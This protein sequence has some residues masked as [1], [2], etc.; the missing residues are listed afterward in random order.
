MSTIKNT[1]LLFILIFGVS[2]G[3][4]QTL[5]KT[6]V[7]GDFTQFSRRFYTDSLFQMSRINFPLKGSHNINVP[8]RGKNI[9]GD[10]IIVGWKKKDW[11]MVTN[12]YFK[13]NETKVKIDNTTY[14]RKTQ[15]G[16][17]TAVIRTYIENSGFEVVEKYAILNGKWYLVY[18]S[19][20]DY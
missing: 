13:N 18:F 4:Q 5:S 10:S 8:I 9:M 20:L 16:T 3:T 6:D 7:K 17:K 1:V 12:T 19:N 2:C 11:R 14:L 15:I